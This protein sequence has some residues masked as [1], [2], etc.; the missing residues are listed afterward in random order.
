M[1]FVLVSPSTQCEKP[2]PMKHEIK[3][4]CCMVNKC[5]L[6]KISACYRKIVF[7]YIVP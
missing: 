6:S 4:T 2:P 5:M 1:K 3:S 7:I